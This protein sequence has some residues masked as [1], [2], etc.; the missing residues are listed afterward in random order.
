MPVIDGELGVVDETCDIATD[1]VVPLPFEAA[2][3]KV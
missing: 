2:T 1:D 3:L